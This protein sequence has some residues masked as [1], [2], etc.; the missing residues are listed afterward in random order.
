MERFRIEWRQGPSLV[1]R[2]AWVID[3]DLT[4]STKGGPFL[5][6]KRLQV[7]VPVEDLAAVG[8]R[9]PGWAFWRAAVAVASGLVIRRVTDERYFDHPSQPF[10]LVPDVA[11]ALRRATEM[12]DAAVE[13]EEL[14]LEFAG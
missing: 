7:V 12:E 9:D 5:L 6:A 11:E 1:A 3:L 4:V 8:V 14:V 13:D 2:E 10:Q